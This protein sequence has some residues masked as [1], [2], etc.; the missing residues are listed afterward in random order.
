MA[1][2]AGYIISKIAESTLY[3]YFKTVEN[4]TRF[5]NGRGVRNQ[6]ES[7]IIRHANRLAKQEM[8]TDEDLR[9]LLPQDAVD[10]FETYTFSAGDIVTH[11]KFGIGTII[12]VDAHKLTIEF[13]N[14]NMKII[15]DSFVKKIDLLG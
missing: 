11:V 3:N 12:D 15:F 13:D 9:T 1:R 4:D 14:S 10:D 6:F 7:A 8:L 2:D 5:G